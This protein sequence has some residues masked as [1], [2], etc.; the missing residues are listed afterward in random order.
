MLRFIALYGI[1]AMKTSANPVAVGST[2]KLKNDI[3]MPYDFTIGNVITESWQRV[4]G[5]KATCWGA[6][7]L[8]VLIYLGIMILGLIATYLYAGSLN[9]DLAAVQIPNA[10]TRI[11][12]A[13]ITFPLPFGIAFI[14]IRRSVNLPVQARQIFDTYQHYWK[15]LGTL[16]I[17]YVTFFLIAFVTLFVIEFLSAIVIKNNGIAPG[18]LHGILI[19]IG[20]FGGL[21]GIYFIFAL[22]YAPLLV[23][24]KPVGVLQAIKTSFLAFKQHGLKIIITWVV[25]IVIYLVSAIPLGIGLIWTIPMLFNCS[26]LLYRIQFGVEESNY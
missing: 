25:M 11:L 18:W 15:I 22:S 8:Y 9:P 16:V 5:V 3:A 7:S 17:L 4:K 6:I 23:I 13:L 12:A 21:T 10:I 14:A 20:T 19:L 24:E 1:L 2:G 26:G